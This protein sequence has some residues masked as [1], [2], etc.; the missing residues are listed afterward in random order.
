M[1][2]MKPART[3]W[4]REKRELTRALLRRTRLR[5]AHLLQGAADPAPQSHQQA[6]ANCPL[7][8]SEEV[9]R[10]LPPLVCA[11][12]V[13]T[14]PWVQPRAPLHAEAS[15]TGEHRVASLRAALALRP[16]LC[17]PSLRT[18]V[19]RLRPP[20]QLLTSKSRFGKARRNLDRSMG[21]GFPPL[22]VLARYKSVSAEQAPSRVSATG[23]LSSIP[24]ARMKRQPTRVGEPFPCS[25]SC[26]SVG[27]G[28]LSTGSCRTAN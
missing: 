7:L 17:L 26:R 19:S 20:S 11:C 22:Q 16:V 18:P 28:E 6:R 4:R 25:L 2:K 27:K 15:P 10:L 13:S 3:S 12:R 1:T 5:G 23:R 24:A 8:R 14:I 21:L 9:W